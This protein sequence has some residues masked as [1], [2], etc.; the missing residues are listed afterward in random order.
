MA[1]KDGVADF[2]TVAKQTIVAQCIRRDVATRVAESVTC[3][4][5]ASYSIIAGRRRT[6]LAAKNGVANF[7]T[8]AKQTIVAQGI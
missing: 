8:V 1:A 7:K 6:R 4:G 3:I 2:G 5:R